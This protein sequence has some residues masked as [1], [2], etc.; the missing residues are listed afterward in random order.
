LFGSPLLLLR[1]FVGSPILV[2]LVAV[3]FVGVIL[4]APHFLFPLDLFPGVGA[5]NTSSVTLPFGTV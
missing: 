4:L 2:A 1:Q 5:F 3:S